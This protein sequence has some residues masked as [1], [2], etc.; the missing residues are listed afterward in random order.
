VAID[1]GKW[2]GSGAQ[3]I[4]VGIEVEWVQGD[5]SGAINHDTAAAQANVSYYTENSGNFDDDQSL[6]LSGAIDGTINF[7]NGAGTAVVKRDTRVWQRD[8]GNCEYG[9]S[10]GERTFAA[11]LR[12][13][14]NGITPS[15]SVTKA[16][17]ARPIAAPLAPTGASA[18]RINDSSIKVTWNNRDTCGEPWGSV[19]VERDAGSGWY[20]SGTPGGGASSFTDSEARTNERFQYRVRSQNSKGSSAWDYTG[21]A[22]TTPGAPSGASRSGAN[23]A[24]QVVTWGNNVGYSEYETEV[25][26]AADDVWDGAPLARVNNGVT[27]YTHPSPDPAKQH[28]YRLRARTTSGPTLYSAYSGTTSATT[29]ATYPPD[30]PSG[31]SPDGLSVDPTLAVTLSWTHN[32]TDG[33]AQTA[34]EVEHRLAGSTAW[35]TTGKAATS[36]ATWPLPANTYEAEQ[37]VEWRA[38]TWGADPDPSPWSTIASFQTILTPIPPDPVKVPLVMDLFTGEVEAST[39]AHEA[40]DYV[41][42]LQSNVMGGGV[43][44]VD[45]SF[46]VSWTQRMIA[47]SLGRSPTTFHRGYHDI[48]NPYGWAVTTK[49]L[50]NNRA[51]LTV[52]TAT[53]GVR[54][55]VGEQ[56]IVSGVGAPFDGTWTVRETTTST[57]AYDVTAADVASTASGGNVY[58]RVHG[59]GGASSKSPVGGK[60][61]LNSWDAL[62]YEMPFGWGSGATARKNGVVKV[63]SKALA[64]NKATLTVPSPHYFAVG[65]R[66]IVEGVGAPFDGE[67]RDVTALTPTTITFNLTAPDVASTPVTGG[68]AR[69]HGKD[70]FFGNFH[71]VNYDGDFV[72]PSHWVLLA[73]RNADLGAV[74]WG[75]GDVVDP[76]F[77]S[78]SPVFK[79]AVFTATTDVTV[80]AGNKPPLRIGDTLGNH[81]R[82]DG[83]EIQSMSGDDSAGGLI[84]NQGGGKVTIANGGGG[85]QLGPSGATTFKRLWLDWRNTTTSAAGRVTFTHNVGTA[86]NYVLVTPTR[87][88]W[89]PFIETNNI[90]NVV[91]QVNNYEGAAAANQSGGMYVLAFWL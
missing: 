6:N 83:N 29:G 1:W 61:T 84:L 32:A 44:A 24:D 28:K 20:L 39:T 30:A 81:M 72:V 63:T 73:L 90:N 15:N 78:D 47:I 60:I 89:I 13:A 19:R 65:D 57:V 18:S 55:R 7:H 5:G 2:E 3:Q 66:F 58:P 23:G 35:A 53:S 9:S 38:R 31:L 91:V 59:Q 26:H 76:G 85:V 37:T 27:S 87:G 10:P 36:G 34:R 64:A 41:T 4:R 12:G 48:D 8:Y 56:V 80:L 54:M 46:G 86:A 14:Y 21:H 49:A 51:T 69:P 42:R 68:L 22:W 52:S 70:T 74:E 17:P 67:G 75:Q 40:R 71:V 45:A 43:R 79:Q 33:T 25:W 62:Y 77:D 11:G 16:I 88:G 82:L 50:T